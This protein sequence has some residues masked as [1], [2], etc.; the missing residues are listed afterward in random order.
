MLRVVAGLGLGLALPLAFAPFEWWWLIPVLLSAWVLLWL[1]Q[2]P[3]SAFKIGFAFGA[4]AFLTGTYWLYHSIHTIGNAPVALAVFLMLGLVA[5]MALYFGLTA[6]LTMRLAA[7]SRIAA[8][9]LFAPTF[10]LLEWL[11]GWVLSGFPWLSLGYALPGGPLAGWL[12][13]GGIYLGSLVL[14]CVASALLMLLSSGRGA[15]I[16]GA[17]VIVVVAAA[18][19]FVSNARYVTPNAER[20]SARIAQLG[21]DQSLKW[22]PEQFQKTVQWYGQFVAEH[23]GADILLM[24]EVALPTVADR[25]EPYLARVGTLANEANSQLL[26]GILRRH[27]DGRVANALL[28]MRDGQRQWYEKRH[29]VPFGEYF[30]VPAFIREWMRLRDLPYAD[31]AAGADS[32]TPIVVDGMTIATSICYEDAYAAEQLVFF[33]RAGFIVNVSNDA[34]FGDSIAPHQHLQI[35]R[36]RSAESQRW[37]LRATNTGITAIIDAQGRVAARAP[38]FEP[39]VLAGSIETVSGH[40]PYTRVGNW[41][42]LMFCFAAIVSI[43]VFRRRR[44]TLS[45]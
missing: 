43:S 41:P 36:T 3:R 6:M 13:I 23:R 30:P 38:S 7:G 14:L 21:L 40:T 28:S 32:Q 5:I 22:S 39:A 19:L 45:D 12:P 2:T 33:P 42:V 9:V 44:G 1:G 37:Q 17:S 24:P 27:E 8:I 15:R 11:R 31:L 29:L 25:I 20:F 34:W 18:S 26:L 4:G 35:A 16:A 10:L